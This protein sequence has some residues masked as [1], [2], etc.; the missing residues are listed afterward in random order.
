MYYHWRAFKASALFFVMS[1]RNELLIN[2]PFVLRQTSIGMPEQPYLV[3][4]A[5]LSSRRSYFMAHHGI[6][7][8]YSLKDSSSLSEDRKRTSKCVCVARASS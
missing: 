7:P 6:S 5:P 2:L 1:L 4:T 3:D 8:S